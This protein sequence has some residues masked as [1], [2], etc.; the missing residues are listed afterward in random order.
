[1]RR[2]LRT[3]LIAVTA[4]SGLSATPA[5]TR[6]DDQLVYWPLVT[7]GTEYRRISYPREAGPILVLADTEVVIEA[8][9]ATVSYWP[10]TREYLADFSKNPASAEGQVE[11]VDASGKVTIVE[12]TLY[13]LW[14]PDGVGLGPTELV[15]GEPTA[16][17]Y[18][19]YVKTAREAAAAAKEYQRVV[20]EHQAI[21]EAWLR[22]AA[23]RPPNLPKP[24]PALSIEEPEPYRAYASEPT[25]ASVVVLPEGEYTIRIRDG[26][27][28]IVPGSERE[29]VSFAPLARAIGYVLRPENRW[30]QPIVTFAPDETIYTTGETDLF[31]QSVPIVEYEAERFTRLFRPQ[32]VEV[33]DSSLTIW[34]P[35]SE[36][37]RVA[38]GTAL[39]LSGG[40]A[41]G[42]VAPLTPYRVAQLPGVARGYAIE[43]F[44][45]AAGVPLQPD[46]YAMRVGGDT[47]ATEVGLLEGSDPVPAS[48]RQIR[49]VTMPPEA[50]LFLPAFLPLA[51]GIAVRFGRRR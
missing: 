24:P 48:E 43:E 10:I 16:A 4:L 38:A 17:F 50:I 27:G 45:P 40:G 34:T 37:D 26:G 28:T 51:V 41:A 20:A 25:A 12:P 22:I 47:A 31:F 42:E 8:K 39:A 32:S 19:D 15:H 21:L 36:D 33:V 11:I 14:H 13:L 7:D 5:A 35:E 6:A 29:L 30:T 2:P 9:S 44:R 1:M 23:E 49:I 18:D 3:L 46:F